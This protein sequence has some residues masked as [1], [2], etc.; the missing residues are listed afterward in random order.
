[1]RLRYVLPVG[2]NHCD[3]EFGYLQREW[4]VFLLI[5][6]LQL[7]GC[8]FEGCTVCC[9]VTGCALNGF[10]LRACIVVYVFFVNGVACGTVE[11]MAHECVAAAE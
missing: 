3:R 8:S 2:M 10:A 5:Y 9:A 4:R 7:E 1:M 11:A 6:R